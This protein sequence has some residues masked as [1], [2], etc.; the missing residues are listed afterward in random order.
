MRLDDGTCSLCGRKWSQVM[1]TGMWHDLKWSRRLVQQAKDDGLPII[2]A[3]KL[4]RERCDV[5]LGRAKTLVTW[6]PA[7]R[8]AAQAAEPLHN[9]CERMM[10]E[11]SELDERTQESK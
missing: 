9:A 2:E 3:I 1:C 5:S 6:H 8:A 10:E 7:Y 11:S 4:V